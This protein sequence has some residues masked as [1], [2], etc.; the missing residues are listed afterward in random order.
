MS[1]KA[2]W[3]LIYSLSIIALGG[4]LYLAWRI[5]EAWRW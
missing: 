3:I 5:G 1:G 2:T 4:A